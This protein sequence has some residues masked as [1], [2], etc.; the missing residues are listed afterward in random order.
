MKLVHLLQKPAS[1]RTKEDLEILFSFL[2]T[3]KALSSY[4]DDK[5]WNLCR[6][7]RYEKYAAQ[8][9]V[10]R[11]NELATCYYILLSGS[12]LIDGR[13][14][15]IDESFGNRNSEDHRRITDCL[16][17]EQ[18]EMMV[19][20]IRSSSSSHLESKPHDKEFVVSENVYHRTTE[21]NPL[22]FMY[23]QTSNL[24]SSSNSLLFEQHNCE[25]LNPSLRQ[26]SHSMDR[27]FYVG[28]KASDTSSLYSGSDLMISSTEDPPIDLTGLIESTVDSDDDDD[29]DDYSE[30]SEF[31]SMHDSLRECLESKSPEERSEKDIEMI[32][33]SV[34]HLPAFNNMTQ[35]TRQS[36]CAVMRYAV[37]EKAETVVMTDGEQL[38]SWS[39]IL[40]GEV[41]IVR[42]DGTINALK[43]GE[44]FGL[45]PTMEKMYHY[46]SMHTKVDNCQFLC[47]TQDDYYRILH[48]GEE[49]IESVNENGVVVLVTEERV[50]DGRERKAR[51][52]I[53]GTPEKLLQQLMKEQSSVDLT[54]IED[55][56][57]TYRTFIPS[58]LDVAK[59][60]LEWMSNP[61]Y[62]EQVI[63]VVA[64]WLDRHY[65][66]F[67]TEPLMMEFIEQLQ[68]LL[69]EQ[70]MMHQLRFLNMTCA[71]KA[72][73]R[74][75]VLNRVERKEILPFNV[76]GGIE[77]GCGIFINNVE[78]GSKAY[79]L[80]LKRGDQILEVNNQNFERI[81]HNSALEIL[82]KSTHLSITVKY[83]ILE[84]KERLLTPIGGSRKDG[85]SRKQSLQMMMS[86]PHLK[87]VNKNVA[88]VIRGN[89]EKSKEDD[90]GS[91]LS[92]GHRNRIRQALVRLNIL[93]R[94]MNSESNL[95][96]GGNRSQRGS[97]S[98]PSSPLI[99]NRFSS[100]HPDLSSLKLCSDDT[101]DAFPD[102]V[103][104]IFKDDQ[105]FRFLLVFRE[106][107]AHEVVML[108][109]KEFGI[110]TASSVF[111]LCEVTVVD[112][113]FVKQRRLPDQQSNL[114][115]KCSLNSRY[116]L[117]YNDR[118]DPLIPDD[119]VNDVLRDCQ[120]NFLHLDCAEM[121]AQLTIKDFQLFRDIQ[122]SE[123]VI[124]LFQCPSKYGTP[125][126]SKFCQLANSEMFWVVTQICKESNIRQRTR[127]IKNFIQIAKHCLECK[128]YNSLFAIIGGLGHGSVQRLKQTWDKLPS[129]YVHLFEDLQ[130]LMDPT[131]NMSRYRNLINNEH[132]HTPVIPFFPLV[133]KDLTFIHL[134]NDSKVA[135]L[136]NFEKL[137]MISKEVRHVCKMVSAFSDINTGISAS[138]AALMR[139]K[140][141]GTIQLNPK[142]M[143]EETQMV[144]KVRA[145]LNNFKIIEDENILNDMSNQSEPT[146][147]PITLG[148]LTRRQESNPSP[149]ILTKQ[150]PINLGPKFGADSPDAVHK[151]M[152]L[153]DRVRPH[154][155]RK[156]KQQTINGGVLHPMKNISSAP[157]I[158]PTVLLSPESSS[159]LGPNQGEQQRRSV[160]K[161]SIGSGSNSANSSIGSN[162]GKRILQKIPQQK[163][164][165]SDSGI[166]S[167]NCDSNSTSST[168]GSP[169]SGKSKPRVS[170]MRQGSMLGGLIQHSTNPSHQSKSTFYVSTSDLS[171]SSST[172]KEIQRFTN[173]VP[174]VIRSSH[175]KITSA[176]G[177][178]TKEVMMAGTRS[179]VPTSETT[180]H[181]RIS[182]SPVYI[183]HRDNEVEELSI[184]EDEAN[185]ISAV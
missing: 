143:Y 166:H 59:K 90:R 184:D 103:L 47:I 100:S 17:L 123:Y 43:Q 67:E 29:D 172:M 145:Y 95:N 118:T 57:L 25:G 129:R 74:L 85:K 127:A 174:P 48:E 7:V 97:T 142:R 104:K 27:Y 34:Q 35:V 9:V 60:L 107:T 26:S 149:V 79:E 93:P 3:H 136:I 111:S 161:D 140:Q 91:F 30:E 112:E 76:L 58:S 32:L 73:P 185:I 141:S 55:F 110:S 98:G 82:R 20:D 159:V 45:T 116:Y 11:R 8:A 6:I 2:H 69:E 180:R 137:R 36:L 175:S 147:L 88:P 87:S 121:A 5:V 52:T 144:R 62:R 170:T 99:K 171:A 165:E 54:Y 92:S 173:H 4:S 134:G 119:I 41:E 65:V 81:S 86:E 102:H 105:S 120:T 160:T 181:R 168:G 71:K 23:P 106:T 1:H 126:L 124:D 155:N 89:K 33:E 139:K 42:P 162:A 16:V 40:D 133:K 64:E 78:K 158:N 150:T 138:A 169:T 46:G 66:D 18:S 50:I 38:D 83:N 154:E 163:L 182:S 157:H 61:A 132:S 183:N 10:F 53:R 12:V 177:F 178:G 176:S 109:L 125:N 152:L 70:N 51:V 108:A 44:S 179:R 167:S 130:K 37:V 148:I 77:R 21:T 84:F 15:I 13:M 128:N 56:L 117:K 68:A 31:S 39:V 96:L 164:S 22:S 131:R 94:N 28:S 14:Y 101:I 153:T 113:G 115:D 49:N 72:K 156:S 114:A 24:R 19:I 80:G 75:V 146:G 122:P 63:S 151:L 135:G